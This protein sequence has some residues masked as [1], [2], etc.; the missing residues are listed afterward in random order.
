MKLLSKLVRQD[1]AANSSSSFFKG[2]L[3]LFCCLG[4]IC[5]LC[6]VFLAF[7]FCLFFPQCILIIL[8]S[9]FNCKEKKTQH[10]LTLKLWCKGLYQYTIPFRFQPLSSSIEASPVKLYHSIFFVPRSRKKIFVC[11]FT[12]NRSRALTWQLQ[13]LGEVKHRLG[14]IWALL[15]HS[16]AFKNPH[17]VFVW[18][19]FKLVVF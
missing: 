13:Q 1:W 6:C 4:A 17:H 5:Y 7:A 12:S 18:T 16:D 15:M 11:F 2:I 19:D 9:H 10:I 3:I 8:N 14:H